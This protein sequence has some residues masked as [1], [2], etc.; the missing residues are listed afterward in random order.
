MDA[1]PV[2]PQQSNHRP[3]GVLSHLTGLSTFESLRV[4]DF[5]LLLLGQ[6]SS[7]MG[8]WMDQ[9]AR[10]WLMYQ[11]TG[12]ALQLGLVTAMRGFP[13]LFFGVIAGTVADKYG[14]KRQLIIAQGT[15]AV[16]SFTLATLVLTGKVMPWHIYATG[17]L[18]GTVQAFQNPARQ[19]LISDLVASR[20]L[21]NALALNSAVS[22][23]ARMIGPAMAGIIIAFAGVQG[24][25]YTETLL[26]LFATVWTVQMRVPASSPN[27]LG[28]TREPFLTSIKSGLSYVAGNRDIRMLMILALAPMILGGPYTS[29][30]PVFAKDVLHGGARLQGLIL[31]FIGIGGFAG[32]VVVASMRRQNGYALSVILGAGFFGIA[33]MAFS[34]SRW[35]LLSLVLGTVIGVFNVT[36][37]TQNQTLLQILAP[38]HLRGRVMSIYLLDRGLVPI[39][40][41][42]AGTLAESL[43]GPTALL[44]MSAASVVVVLLVALSSPSFVRLQIPLGGEAAHGYSKRRKGR[45]NEKGIPP[46]V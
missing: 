20:S 17:F 45:A 39:G 13:L 44:I 29:L 9:V 43:G 4:R 1:H 19:T 42:L 14:R 18:A 5:R 12:S 46:I 2:D 40:S 10:G 23:L 35:P 27:V 7:H 22:N 3:H 38:D 34:L 37:R 41:L 36:Y 16:I 8:Q 6:A 25:Y 32:A 15:N 31:T 30:M 26:Y 33:L 21:M 11:I 28:S 24:S